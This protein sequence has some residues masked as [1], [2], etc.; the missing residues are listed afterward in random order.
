[1][2]KEV[3]QSNLQLREDLLQLQQEHERVQIE[4]F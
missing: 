2:I 3:L 1:M 4:N